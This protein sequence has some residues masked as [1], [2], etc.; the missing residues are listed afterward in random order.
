[1]SRFDPEVSDGDQAMFGEIAV[2]EGDMDRVVARRMPRSFR[3]EARQDRPFL[4][5][6]E[7]E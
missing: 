2:G 4:A 1:M 6:A 5:H 7:R 3:A